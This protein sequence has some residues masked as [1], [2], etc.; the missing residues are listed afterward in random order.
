MPSVSRIKKDVAAD[1]LNTTPQSTVFIDDV[2]FLVATEGSA[3]VGGDVVVVSDVTVYVE[4]KKIAVEGAI[5]ASG[6]SIGKSSPTVFAG[7]GK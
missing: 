4:N 2:P 3:T 1:L 7:N 5:M 6:A